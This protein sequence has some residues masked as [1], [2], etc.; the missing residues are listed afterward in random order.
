MTPEDRYPIPSS[1][2]TTVASLLD[3]ARRQLNAALREAEREVQRLRSALEALGGGGRRHGAKSSAPKRSGQSPQ[4]TRAKV[5]T[6][7][8]TSR[9]RTKPATSAGAGASPRRAKPSGPTRGAGKKDTRQA[10]LDAVRSNPATNAT[11]LT[12]LTGLSMGT[13]RSRLTQLADEG[14]IRREGAGAR[15]SWHPAE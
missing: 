14:L 1:G 8:A 6:R 4:S 9:A 11:K 12:A 5:P 10:V 7:P 3:T 13:V 2:G 15:S